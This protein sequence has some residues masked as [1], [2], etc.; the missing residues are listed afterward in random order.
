MQ[1]KKCILISHSGAVAQTECRKRNLCLDRNCNGLNVQVG[2]YCPP[3]Y[4]A[5]AGHPDAGHLGGLVPHG[6]AVI[7]S[8]PASFRFTAVAAPARHLAAAEA[9]GADIRGAGPA[10]AGEVGGHYIDILARCCFAGLWAGCSSTLTEMWVAD[11]E[12][13]CS[14]A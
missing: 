7:V 13:L 14:T 11:A 3:G 5:P 10:D 6:M 12:K 4:P 1:T 2:D 8:A 9:L